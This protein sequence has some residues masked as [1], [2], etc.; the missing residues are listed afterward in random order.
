[1]NGQEHKERQTAVAILERTVARMDTDF[2]LLLQQEK[3]LLTAE[4]EV[5]V[6]GEQ[7][8]REELGNERSHRLALA[9]E[10]RRY[11]DLQDAEVRRHLAL[12]THMPVWRRWWWM[13][14]GGF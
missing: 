2:S 11:V 5:R 10:Q 13:L 6:N 3:D 9:G 12:F 4:I 14:G 7:G 8:L 1:M